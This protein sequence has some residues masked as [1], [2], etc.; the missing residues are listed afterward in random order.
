MQIPPC[1]QATS[2]FDVL[3]QLWHGWW[4]G[5]FTVGFF[6]CL[7]SM[8]CLLVTSWC[9]V[10]CG[11]LLLTPVFY[12]N[13]PLASFPTSFQRQMHTQLVEVDVD[14]PPANSCVCFLAQ[15]PTKNWIEMRH[16]ALERIPLS[17]V[18]PC[19]PLVVFS[20]IPLHLGVWAYG[21]AG[22]VNALGFPTSFNCFWTN[23]DDNLVTER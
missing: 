20:Q 22:L 7:W 17:N 9:S 11:W 2:R 3:A 16:A 1:I 12:F 5:G 4:G 21:R 6:F 15:K 13:S 19:S 10:C 23:A 18:C 14:A 8:G